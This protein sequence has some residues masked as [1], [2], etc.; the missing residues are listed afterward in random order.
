VEVAAKL[1]ASGAFAKCMG[2][3]LVNYALADVSSGAATIDSCAT[4]RVA[5]RIAASDGTFPGLVKA[6][7]T[8]PAFSQRVQGVVQ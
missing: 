3:N 1:A 2:Q 8:S 4:K 6:V 7:A 5:E